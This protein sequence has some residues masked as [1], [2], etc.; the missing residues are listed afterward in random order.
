MIDTPGYSDFIGQVISSLHVVETAV[1]VVKSA[2]GVEVG[3][4]AAWDYVKQYELPG[5]V[6]INKVDNEHSTFK[7]TVQV[8][9][10]HLSSDATVITLPVKEGLNFTTV[11]DLIKMKAF[12][13]GEAGSKKVTEEEIPADLKEEVETMR[14]ELIEKVAE[15]SEELMNKFFEEG[16]LNEDDLKKGL[17]AAILNRSLVPV[18]AVSATK[19]VGLNNFLDFAVNYFPSPLEAPP[20][21]AK[22]KGKDEV[23]VKCDPKGEVAALVFKSLSEQHVGELSIT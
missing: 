12:T 2:E 22:M 11:V 6:I 14:E 13:Y 20:A 4:E 8:V 15:S 5:A 17:K 10:D 9:K 7:E 3:T 21:K 19:G 1:A 18:F 16:T 23:E